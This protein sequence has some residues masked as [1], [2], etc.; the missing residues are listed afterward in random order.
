MKGAYILLIR[1]DAGR[2]IR[3]GGLGVI[4]FKRGYYAYAGSAMGGIYHRIIRHLSDDKK[5]RW[6]IDYFLKEGKIVEVRCFPS[7]VKEE[8]RI[9]AVYQRRF[10]S[11]PG[12]G[13]GDCR[14]KSHLFYSARL[15]DLRP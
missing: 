10:E 7:D 12:F 8:C 1:L 9:A 11:I 2:E 3:I 14:C 5:M 4:R 6:H 15:S 13:C